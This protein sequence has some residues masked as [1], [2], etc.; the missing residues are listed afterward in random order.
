MK[1]GDLFEYATI[2]IV[3]LVEREE[4]INVGVILY[5]KAQGFLEMKY[6]V[7]RKRLNAFNQNIS[8]EE[9][10]QHLEAFC[11][12]CAA[13]GDS[14]EIGKLSMPERFRWL[15]GSRSTVIQASKVHP[16]LCENAGTMLE[17]LFNTMVR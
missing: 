10:S 2:R 16:G 14:G 1:K 3:P 13:T 9:I 6:A 11:K 5:C 4:F 12:I 17:E 15:T 8:I 7:D